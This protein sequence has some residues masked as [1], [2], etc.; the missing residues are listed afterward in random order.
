VA[1]VRVCT[2]A[3]RNPA[4]RSADHGFA[5]DIKDP[6]QEAKRRVALDMGKPRGDAEGMRHGALNHS[7]CIRFQ[8][9]DFGLMP[10]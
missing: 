5:Q 3:I 7:L 4:R 8:Q 1:D 6:P 2:L 9:K 10:Y